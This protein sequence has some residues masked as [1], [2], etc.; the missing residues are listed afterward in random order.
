MTDFTKLIKKDTFM[1]KNFR[2]LLQVVFTAAFVFATLNSFSAGK[3]YKVGDKGP[4]GGIVFFITDGGIHGLEAAP[5]LWMGGT[6]DPKTT[7]SNIFTKS[8]PGTKTEIG[9]G[10][11]NTKAI[12]AQSGHSTS[13]AK[14]C[15]DYN[16][17]GM[18]DWYLPSKD[19]LNELYKQKTA[20]FGLTERRYWSSS[21]GSAYG[22]WVQHFRIGKQDNLNKEVQDYYVRAVRSF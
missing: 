8:V 19:E 17:G 7:W 18:K 13:A 15:R 1:N 4:G 11:E 5:S 20:A 9:S 21:E 12:I 22:A 6:E 2:L 16:G 14:L 10:M 3:A